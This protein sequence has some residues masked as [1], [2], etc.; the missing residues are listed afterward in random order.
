M[1]VFQALLD[2]A[3]RIRASLAAFATQQRRL[4]AASPPAPRSLAEQCGRALA[5]IADAL[6]SGREPREATPIWERIESCAAELGPS[7]AVDTLLGQIRAAWRIAGVMTDDGE[8]G[9]RRSRLR[10]AAP[11]SAGSRRAHDARART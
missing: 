11:P 7:P 8:A 1:L 6:E 5:E 3:E 10:A 4:A 2:E 9:A